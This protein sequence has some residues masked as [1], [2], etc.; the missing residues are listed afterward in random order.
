MMYKKSNNLKP[1]MKDLTKEYEYDMNQTVEYCYK[2]RK[3]DFTIPNDTQLK[4]DINL[5]EIKFI[6]LYGRIRYTDKSWVKNKKITLY[7]LTF[8]N[9]KTEYVPICES[10]TDN[11]GFYEF[12]IDKSLDD[13]KFK[14]EVNN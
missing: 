13:S 2:S 6:K 12:I 10:C 1:I 11:F 5:N 4:M 9:Y 7:L 3:I 8:L 14:I